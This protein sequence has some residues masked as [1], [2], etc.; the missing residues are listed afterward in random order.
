MEEVNILSMAAAIKENDIKASN[1]I[2]LGLAVAYI[3][4]F[5]WQ[6]TGHISPY[7]PHWAITAVFLFAQVIYLALGLGIRIGKRWARVLFY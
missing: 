1:L 3:R 2:F 5:I 7:Y 4:E 6:V